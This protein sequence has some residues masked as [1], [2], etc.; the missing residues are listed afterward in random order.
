MV[1]AEEILAGV[2]L[3][4]RY[5]YVAEDASIN[6]KLGFLTMQAPFTSPRQ[7]ILVGFGVPGHQTGTAELPESTYAMTEF[8]DVPKPQ[9]TLD[10]LHM[11]VG[12]RLYNTWQGATLLPGDF[13][14][15][16][17]YILAVGQKGSTNSLFVRATPNMQ[18]WDRIVQGSITQLLGL[19]KA[20]RT[21]HWW[22]QGADLSM[23]AQEALASEARKQR[24]QSPLPG[25]EEK[26]AV[27]RKPEI[28]LTKIGE[29]HRG[30]LT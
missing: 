10:N 17:A 29:V 24:R 25:I 19:K 1:S 6:E 13:Q 8:D 9:R 7:E 4:D 5:R 11:G 2:Q 23:H 3:E 16:G 30:Q 15:V 21:V 26:I 27:V 28:L 20:V 14:H 12:I 18:K 22:Q